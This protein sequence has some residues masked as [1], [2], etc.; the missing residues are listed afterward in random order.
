MASK[1]LAMKAVAW[2]AAGLL[3]VAPGLAQTIYGSLAGTVYDPSGA[4]IP[5][6]KV[7]ITNLDTGISREIATDEQGFWRA[8]SLQAGRYS[9]EVSVT[10]FETVV[11][12]PLLVESAVER[13]VDLTLK[14]SA[15]R[16]VVTVHEESP[17]I[18]A[19]RAQISRGVESRRILELPGGNTLTGLALLQPGVTPNDQGRPGSGF[20]VNG[21]RTRSNNFMIDGANNN[22]QSLM[23]PRQTVAPEALG[24]FRIITNNFSAEFGR[25]AGSVVQQV[26]K[27]GTNE[28]HGIARWSWLGNGLNALTTAQQRTFNAQKA[29]GL[30]DYHALRRSRGVLV[31]NQALASAGGPI[32]RNRLFF[33]TSYDFDRRRSTAMPVAVTF[34]PE[35]YRLLDENKHLFAPGTVDFL[36]A[37]Y[38]V[39][40]DPTAQ[41][42]VSV[43]L[44]DGRVLALT[45]QQYS[46][47]QGQALSYG[48]DIHRGLMKIDARASDNDNLS[49]RYMVD[50]DWDPGSPASLPVNQLG[51]AGRNQNAA[52]NHVRVW[53]PNINSEGRLVYARRSFH[54]PENFPAQFSISGSGLPTIGNQN[55]PQYRT[56][57]LYEA[58]NNWHW[59]RSAHTIRFGFNYMQYRLNS[60]FAPATRGVI[61][62]P[63]LEDFLYDRRG[64][65]SQYAG[66]G[67][68]PAR[69][70]EFQGFFAD[71]WRVTDTVTINLGIRYEYTSAPFGFFSDAKADINNWAPRF[72]FAWSPRRSEGLLGLLSGNGKLA[73]R[74]G[75]AVSYDQ[76]FQNILLN[77]SRN[78]PRGVTVSLTNLTG[79]RLWDPAS[80][81]A[82][83]TPDDFIRLGGNPSL[84]PVRLF[85]PNKRIGQPYSQQYSLGIERQ[86]FGTYA[87]KLFYVGTRGIRLVREV[88]SN[89]GFYK[90]A[91]DAN[92]SI[93]AGILPTLQPTTVGGQAA[94]RRD[95][96]RGS[97]LVGDG[98]GQ[99]T[100]HSMQVTVEKRFARGLQFEANYTWSSFIND[101][102]DILGGQANRTLPSVPFNHRLDRARSG[103]D[104]PHRFVGNY[105]YQLPD[106]GFQRGIA[107]RIF[108]GWQVSGITTIN[109]GSPYSILNA[110]NALGILPGQIATIHA[111]QRAGYNPTGA[112]RSATAPNVVNPRWI[113][114]PANSGLIGAG[115][116]TERL[117]TTNNFDMALVKNIRTFSESQSLQLRWEVFNVFNHRNFN[118]IPA[119]TASANTSQETFQNLGYTNVA[120]REMLFTVRYVW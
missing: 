92:P 62:Y 72:G 84:L 8:P 96:N 120:G 66:T 81:P 108:A 119:N 77:N 5:S 101:T 111:S 20:V 7:V 9:V 21:A 52:L 98:F 49:I 94:Y 34:S 91:A 113:A 50:D 2:L 39:A 103:Y 19:T 37:T 11:R 117:G 40:N 4:V 116:N 107:N 105:I 115:A 6:A 16:E 29:A 58:T 12:A 36:R 78:F 118:Q 41:G 68:V 55:F 30:S 65:F 87:F 99:S 24:E 93:Y 32:L 61:T 112:P 83:P 80:R 114:Y 59:I 79:A 97:I 102:D 3:L 89:I 60:F 56:D 53:A 26:T 90:A 74:G 15:T 10:G 31:R 69:T 38:P 63:S 42:S 88:E 110:N 18:E 64:E 100:Y 27:S 57:N 71:D 1:T 46:R 54:F 43:R 75:Y 76:V 47:G 13:R 67:S 104:Q 14:P 25:N 48:R 82:P 70:H 33:F 28:F 106:F 35:A 85:S 44:P 109:T 23:T 95:P 45:R 73:V 86:F 51:T 22:D 17:L